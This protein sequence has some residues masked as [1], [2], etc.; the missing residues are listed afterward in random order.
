MVKKN[1]RIKCKC[2]CKKSLWKFDKSGRS[3]KFINGHQ[4]KGKT[5][6]KYKIKRPKVEYHLEPERKRKP[7]KVVGISLMFVLTS[8]FPAII[9]LPK[10]GL[11]AAYI[12]FAMYL[13]A[14]F[15]MGCFVTLW[16]MFKIF[17]KSY[18]YNH[19]RH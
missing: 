19:S 5:P 14:L 6:G 2:G 4:N 18:P 16:K 11:G 15:A 17:L 10:Y 13:T 8:L 3:R 1:L 7:N 9:I 12:T